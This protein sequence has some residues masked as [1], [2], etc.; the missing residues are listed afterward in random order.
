MA[1]TPDSKGYWLVAA[2]G[3]VF[4]FGNANYYGSGAVLA[5]PPPVNSFM[6]T[7]LGE[8]YWLSAFDGPVLPFQSAPYFGS[9]YGG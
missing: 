3:G 1:S 8:G 5:Q 7:G 2:D 6:R 4:A 9:Q